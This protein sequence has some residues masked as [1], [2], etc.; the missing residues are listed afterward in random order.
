M[1]H[2]ERNANAGLAEVPPPSVPGGDLNGR[3]GRIDIEDRP[4]KGRVEEASDELFP[5]SDA[6]CYTPVGYVDCPPPCWK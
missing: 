5:A 1:A 3:G 4:G 2:D 6:P